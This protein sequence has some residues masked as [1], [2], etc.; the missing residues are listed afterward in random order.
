MQIEYNSQQRETNINLND[1]S[2]L[3]TNNKTCYNYLNQY[4]NNN[5]ILVVIIGVDKLKEV[6]IV[7]LLELKIQLG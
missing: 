5:N 6:N 7:R 3:Y 4:F 2:S 1:Y